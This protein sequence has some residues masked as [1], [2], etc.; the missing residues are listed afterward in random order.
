V[1][2]NGTNKNFNSKGKNLVNPLLNK[3]A[4]KTLKLENILICENDPAGAKTSYDK[5]F[6]KIR[7]VQDISQ[8]SG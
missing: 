7:P 4:N 5:C 8:Q 6:G 3:Q 1:S 2:V